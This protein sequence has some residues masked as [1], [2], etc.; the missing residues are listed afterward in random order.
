MKLTFLGSGSAFTVGANNYQSNMIIESPQKKR[1]LIDCGTDARFALTE[2]GMTDLDVDAIYISH[3]HSDH[4]GGLE[5]LA[6]N[7][8]ANERKDKIK[9]YISETLVDE[10]WDKVLSGGL[11]FINGQYANLSTY[12]EVHPIQTNH[13]FVWEDTEFQLIQTV[14]VMSGFKI[15]P[16]F[17]LFFYVKNYP[18]YI[19]TDTQYSPNQIKEFY[20]RAQIIF[21][22]CETSAYKSGVHAHFKDLISLLPEV[23][24]KMW[25]YHYN[26]GPLPD[27]KAEGFLG[28]VK[29]GQC[30]DF[31]N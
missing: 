12:F 6:F 30:F 8:I 31:N 18:V 5:W 3:L 27:E 23:K 28:F 22:D 21:Q 19:T 2:L 24:K 1:L 10:L 26:P 7:T 16:S 15:C 4:V 29:K 9:L 25:L 17:G 20:E 14:H 11:S 13:S